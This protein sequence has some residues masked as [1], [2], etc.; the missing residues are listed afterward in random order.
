VAVPVWVRA[1]VSVMA[2]LLLKYE[3]CDRA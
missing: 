2:Q 3:A 1:G